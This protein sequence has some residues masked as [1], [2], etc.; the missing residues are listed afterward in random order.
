MVLITATS[1][2]DG[3]NDVVVDVNSVDTEMT[4]Y[5]V[6]VTANLSQDADMLPVMSSAV[7]THL[8]P[9]SHKFTAPKG[10]STYATGVQ[11]H[12]LVAISDT[13]T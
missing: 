6:L 1:A 13:P 10:H 8:N 2:E 5:W 12:F 4:V 9:L 7:C 3:S 11:S